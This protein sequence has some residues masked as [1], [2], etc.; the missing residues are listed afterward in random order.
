MGKHM[1]R[2][3]R[4]ALIFNSILHVIGQKGLHNFSIDHVAEH[5]KCGLSTV[6][7]H[8]GNLKDIREE[9]VRYA[10]QKGIAPVDQI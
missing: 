4:R 2:I 7:I 8:F 6:K 9:V 10:Q 5:A 1:S 3:E